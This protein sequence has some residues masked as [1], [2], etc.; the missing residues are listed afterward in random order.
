M[1]NIS[2]MNVKFLPDASSLHSRT[3]V[4][5]ASPSDRS[6]LLPYTLHG[7]EGEVYN[8][9]AGVMILGHPIPVSSSLEK[10]NSEKDRGT[11]GINVSPV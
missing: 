6:R 1:Y 11:D 2:I 9:V 5:A 7:E 3:L 10:K 4:S 8:D